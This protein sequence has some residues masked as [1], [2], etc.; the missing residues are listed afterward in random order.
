MTQKTV[1]FVDDEPFILRGYLR[2]TEEFEGEWSVF[3][4]ESAKAALEILVEQPIDVIVTDMRMPGMDGKELLEIVSRQFPGVVRFVLSGNTENLMGLQFTNLAHQFLTK[5]CD[6]TVL[7]NSIDQIFHLR[8]LMDNPRLIKVINSIRKLP[9]PPL[10]YNRLMKEIQ[11]E[12]STAKGIG[13]IIAQ[14]M[15]LTAKILQIA[16]SAFIGM[17]G[18]ITDPQW[19]VTVLGINTIKAVVLSVHVFSEA[20]SAPIPAI[21]VDKLWRHSVMVGSI[22]RLIAADAGKDLQFQND[23]QVVGLMH[24]IGK[25]LQ[26]RLPDYTDRLRIFNR[27]LTLQEEYDIFQTSHAEM[28]AYLLGIWG[29]PFEIIEATAFHHLPDKLP[30]YDFKLGALTHIANGLYY[31]HAA[32]QPADYEEHLDLKFLE[33]AGL[34]QRMERWSQMAGELIEK[35]NQGLEMEGE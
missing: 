2:A 27:P 23:A 14:D 33:K 34:A 26:L 6:L 17:S 24:D 20:E 28:G 1:L 8:R 30:G 31:M 32:D 4:A 21:S 15:A 22:A 18:K 11:S 13:E 19:A 29:L 5:P 7:K 35:H 9:S 16:N 10:L 12:K 3:T 25:L